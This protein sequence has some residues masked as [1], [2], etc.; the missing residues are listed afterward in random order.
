M[1]DWDRKLGALEARVGMGSL[2]GRITVDQRYAAVQHN[3]KD[4]R[5][6]RG[7]QAEYLS[8]PL[9]RLLPEHMQHLADGLLDGTL[10]D[11]MADNMEELSQEVNTL[12]PLDTGILRNSGHPT[13]IDNGATVYDRPPLAP[14]RTDR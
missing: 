11:K 4:F 12:A 13:V 9:I 14:R 2:Q 8:Q 1:D 6:P 5:H 7:G 10:V 3:R